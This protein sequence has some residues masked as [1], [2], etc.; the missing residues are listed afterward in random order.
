MKGDVN[1]R[2]EPLDTD[3]HFKPHIMFAD[4]A[5]LYYKTLRICNLQKTYRFSCTLLTFGLD[6]YTLAYCGV[7]RLRIRNAGQVIKPLAVILL[8]LGFLSY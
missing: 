8:R 3:E 6:K 1:E 2:H 7:H 5:G 4:K